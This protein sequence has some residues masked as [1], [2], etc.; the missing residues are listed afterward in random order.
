MSTLD[1]VQQGRDKY[2][3][4]GKGLLTQ[5][6]SFNKFLSLKLAFLVLSAACMFGAITC[7]LYLTT[8]S[9]LENR[10]LHVCF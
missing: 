8:S 2:A 9:N 3:A 7:Q 10:H 4:K 5:M 6:E 1:V